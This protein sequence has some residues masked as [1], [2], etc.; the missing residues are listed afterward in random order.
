VKL[1][2]AEWELTEIAIRDMPVRGQHLDANGPFVAR[3]CKQANVDVGVDA[4]HVATREFKRSILTDLN[5]AIEQG[6]RPWCRNLLT[7][8]R[9]GMTGGCR[10]VARPGRLPVLSAR[11]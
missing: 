8:H 9:Q 5:S 1:A 2:P 4:I 3:G 11:S 10:S 7:Q 6:R